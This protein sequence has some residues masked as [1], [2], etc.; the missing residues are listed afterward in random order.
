M[1]RAYD[2]ENPKTGEVREVWAKRGEKPAVPK[3][4]V[5]CEVPRVTSVCPKGEEPQNVEVL[6]GFKKLEEKIGGS[7]IER[8]MKMSANRIKQV[9]ERD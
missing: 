1:I 3:G 7:T 4:F 6:R 9:W 5:L 8:G 2:I